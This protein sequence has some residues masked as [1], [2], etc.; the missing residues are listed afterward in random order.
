MDKK[1]NYY[2]HILDS[3]PYGSVYYGELYGMS[4]EDAKMLYD[5]FN[6]DS[7]FDGDD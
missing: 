7:I 6:A 5:T 4:H 1:F 2:K 3:L